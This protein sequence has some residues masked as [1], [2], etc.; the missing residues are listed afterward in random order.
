MLQ[1]RCR[2]AQVRLKSLLRPSSKRRT[3]RMMKTT[4]RTTRRRMM[5]MR[6]K[7]RTSSRIKMSRRTKRSKV[8]SKSSN[9]RNRSRR[10]QKS[11][12]LDVCQSRTN[13]HHRCHLRLC[14]K[15]SAVR[16]M[17]TF[18]TKNSLHQT[19]LK[20]RKRKKVFTNRHLLSRHNN[21]NLSISHLRSRSFNRCP[22]SL[23]KTMQSI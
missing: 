1:A 15:P 21:N 22:R 17:T 3:M 20:K 8:R 6:K 18:M 11:S 19:T 12:Q 4:T 13:G 7:K 2:S 16:A 23:I 9:S 14:L 10:S 5:T